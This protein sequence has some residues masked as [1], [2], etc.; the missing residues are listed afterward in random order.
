[1]SA[2]A[3]ELK[4]NGHDVINLTVGEPDWNTFESAKFHGI[5]AIQNNITR[6][7][8]ASG[9]PA[10]RSKLALFLTDELKTEFKS[11]NI[12]VG[13]GA[14]F[15]IYAAFQ[16]L[17]NPNDEVLLPAPYWVS[18]PTMI[19]LCGAKTIVIPTI[20]ENQFKPLVTQLEAA[21][22]E[23]TRLLVLCSPNNPT[24][25]ALNSS[26]I[27]EIV[28]FLMRHPHIMV[29]S[30]DIYNRLYFGEQTV[31]PHILHYAPELKDRVI[32]IGGASKSFAMTGWRIGWLAA[33]KELTAK[34]ADY[35]SQTTSNPSSISQQ[36]LLGVLG[37]FQA[38]LS[39]SL[40]QLKEKKIWVANKLNNLK[41]S[42]VN[43]DGAFYF[44]I[45]ISDTFGKVTPNGQK[46]KNSLDFAEQLLNTKYVATVAGSDFGTEGW[47]RISFACSNHLLEDGL[48][49]I[50]SFIKELA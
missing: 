16:M 4:A 15:L 41:I 27:Q 30:D 42:F 39:S 28:K 8:P 47:I 45:K 31:A 11:D 40:Q 44:F 22:T 2:R 10:L 37:N 50:A 12:A 24:G 46:I 9:T 18:Y 21:V 23:K 3:N 19:E 29:L 6:Y 33:P 48:N 35:L 17:L 1:M 25:T 13:P 32:C 5:L 14:K 20:F 43:P 7:T 26:E 38:E 34:I 49:R 36:A